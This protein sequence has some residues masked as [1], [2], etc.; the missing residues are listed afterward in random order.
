MQ[1]YLRYKLTKHKNMCRIRLLAESFAARVFVM[2]VQ[3]S[4][5][6]ISTYSALLYMRVTIAPAVLV[7]W[8]KDISKLSGI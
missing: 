8:V 6:C 3:F 1:N 5:K 7:V 2:F 4:S